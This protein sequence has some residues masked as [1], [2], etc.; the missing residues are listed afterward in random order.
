MKSNNFVIIQGWMCN[1][2]ELKGNDLL[3]YALIYGFSQDGES[4]FS[5]S[6][7]YIANTFN[8][9]KPTVDKALN[10]LLSKGL[11]TKYESEDSVTPNS[12]AVDNQVVKK[13]YMGSK[14]TLLGGSK[15]TL[16]NKTNKKEISK[17]DSNS[18]ELLQ[19][20][21]TSFLGSVSESKKEEKPKKKNLYEKCLDSIFTFTQDENL[22]EELI[23]FLKLRLEIAREDG[24][25]LYFGVW[26][27]LLNE[28]RNL[29]WKNNN[30]DTE[31]ACEIVNRSTC[32]G[33]KHFYEIT[34][35]DYVK[36]RRFASDN[37]HNRLNESG[38]TN[39]P[40][41]TKEEEDELE[42]MILSG[43]L[44]EY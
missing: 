18:K 40:H 24:R 31:L 20:S 39:V 37:L 13:L 32:R 23:T 26:T 11:I 10:N 33:W 27:H 12:Y 6:R 7:E 15:E 25:P 28:L 29:A 21:E 5:G 44:Q 35:N 17:K 22:R 41:I 9:S 38:T 3:I 8:I 30:L 43:E 1:E 16:L 34:S 36:S 14:E 2:L 4:V 42:R 19:N